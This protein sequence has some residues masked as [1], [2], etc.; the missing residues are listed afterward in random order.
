MC[1]LYYLNVLIFFFT[2]QLPRAGNLQTIQVWCRHVTS[3]KDSIP[4]DDTTNFLLARGPVA[5]MI[6]ETRCDL[7]KSPDRVCIC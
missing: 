4:F 2:Y 1:H 7:S 5:V 3:S 6:H